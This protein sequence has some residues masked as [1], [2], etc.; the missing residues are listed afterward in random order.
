MK[1]ISVGILAHVDA[2]K[3]TLSEGLLYSSGALSRL[4]RVD[5]RD[6]FLDTHSIERERGITIFSK[7]AILE[8]GNTSMTLIDTP[9]HV[10]FSCEAERALSVQ[11]YAI[12]IVSAADCVT[13]HTKTLYSL[14]SS[15][16][17]PVFIFVNKVDIAER[18]RAQLMEEIRCVL[19]SSA[20]DFSSD[21]SDEFYES[22][23]ACD[24]RLMEEYFEKST[25][26]PAS[27]AMA[28]SY[29]QDVTV[30]LAKGN[31]EKMFVPGNTELTFTL[32]VNADGSLTLSYAT[33]VEVPAIPEGYNTVTIH[34]LKPTNWGGKVNAWVWDTNG[35]IPGYELYQTAWPGSPIPANADKAGWYDLVIGTAQPQA[36]NFIFNDG[37][38]Q[39]ADL[40]TGSITGPT[41]LWVV[42]GTV[43]T[44]A[45]LEWTHYT[46]TIH[47]QKPADWGD[48]VSAYMWTDAGELLGNWPGTVAPASINEGWYTA[49]VHVEIGRTLNFIFNNNNNGKQTADL[50]AG[51]L[52]GNVELWI[53]GSGNTV[54]APSGASTPITA[55]GSAAERPIFASAVNGTSFTNSTA[56][57]EPTNTSEPSLPVI[58]A[59]PPTKS[60]AAVWYSAV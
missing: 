46:A 43:Y 21:T 26:S 17:I 20:V 59:L 51:K 44:A 55:V 40:T 50:T 18:S 38:S 15:R 45:P 31:N 7:Q 6:A 54:S 47:F 16:R 5:K 3:T 12:L 42:D 39:T 1:K 8:F 49:K 32:V 41:E 9:G 57:R 2:G 11:D 24:E 19:S 10:D 27:I 48:T 60:R 4:G 56:V 52:T 58:F 14:L 34:F 22:A 36:F 33:V 25:L 13:A 30:A 37:S 28:A 35:A 29:C 23:A 53:D